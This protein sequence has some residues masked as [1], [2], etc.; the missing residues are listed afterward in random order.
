M[1]FWEILLRLS[2]GLCIT[3]S[4]IKQTLLDVLYFMYLSVCR[5]AVNVGAFLFCSLPYLLRQDFSLSLDFTHLARLAVF[6][7]YLPV[8]AYR[9]APPSR[10]LHWCW[11]PALRSLWLYSKCLLYLWNQFLS[12]HGVLI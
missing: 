10:A 5:L 2:L 9:C 11:G 6:C 3:L 1:K 4:S 7:L 12:L 8:L